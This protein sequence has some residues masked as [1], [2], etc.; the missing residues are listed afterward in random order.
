M[1]R[2]RRHP[3]G[4]RVYVLGRRCHHGV[5]GAAAALAAYRLRRYKAAAILAAWAATDYRDFPFTD[6]RNH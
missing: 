5:A 6:S 4:P 3:R 1:I 2:V